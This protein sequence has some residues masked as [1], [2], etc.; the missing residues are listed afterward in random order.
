MQTILATHF[1]FVCSASSIFILN[2]DATLSRGD[3]PELHFMVGE[4]PSLR[5][6]NIKQRKNIN[7]NN[8]N[9][10]KKQL[11]QN[12]LYVLER[13]QPHESL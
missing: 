7:N 8:N 5:E 1:F 4:V 6:E 13:Q 12:D 11:K 3:A 10:I 2:S 9:V